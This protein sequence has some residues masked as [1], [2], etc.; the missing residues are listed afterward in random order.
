MAKKTV[1]MNN[2]ELK[3]K[4]KT[5][6][7]DGQLKPVKE[8]KPAKEKPTPEQLEAIS[9]GLTKAGIQAVKEMNEGVPEAAR[10]MAARLELLDDF[11]EKLKKSEPTIDPQDVVEMLMIKARHT[12]FIHCADADP[13][14][15][16]VWLIQIVL[17]N[18]DAVFGVTK[19][20]LVAEEPPKANK[21]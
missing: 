9:K 5:V 17:H 13:N 14:R 15:V 20:H 4:D 3:G 10:K 11:I 6:R 7:M 16:I 12:A 18:A 8:K 21:K 1:V 19:A 2:G